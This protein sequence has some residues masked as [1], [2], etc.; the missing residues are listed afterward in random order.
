MEHDLVKAG[1]SYTSFIR[2]RIDP[3]HPLVTE[4]GGPSEVSQQVWHNKDPS[5]LKCPEH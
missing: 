1:V 3:P 2:A 5:L 4:W